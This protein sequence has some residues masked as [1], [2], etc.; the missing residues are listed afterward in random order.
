MTSLLLSWLISS[1]FEFFVKKNENNNHNRTHTVSSD[2]AAG[3]HN[4]SPGAWDSLYRAPGTTCKKEIR[5]PR[6]GRDFCICRSFILVAQNAAPLLQSRVLV[7]RCRRNF[8][9]KS[10][11]PFRHS[12]CISMSFIFIP[13]AIKSLLEIKEILVNDNLCMPRHCPANL[14]EISKKLSTESTKLFVRLW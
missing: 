13:R 12:R 10:L 6:V 1:N 14:I 9:E 7:L 2:K 11:C 5:P 4:L 8:V 3:M